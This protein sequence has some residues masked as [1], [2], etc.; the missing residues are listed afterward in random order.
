MKARTFYIAAL[1]VVLVSSLLFAAPDGVGRVW[2]FPMVESEE[3]LTRWLTDN[4]FDPFRVVLGYG[5]IRL[6][7]VKENEC[8]RITLKP[9]SPLAT[10]IRALYTQNGELDEDK[11]EVLWVHLK[12]Y[13]KDFHRTRGDTDQAIPKAILSQKE[14]VVCIKAFVDREHIQFSGFII[15]GEGLIISTAH[16]LQGIQE[17]TVSLYN[18]RQRNGHIV[19]IDFDRDVALLKIDMISDSF[20]SLAGGRHLV[21]TGEKIYS[22]GCPINHSG[23]IHSGV[24]TGPPRRANGL[25]LLQVRMEVFPGSSGSPVFDAQGHV[26]GMVKGRYRGTNSVGFLIPLDT[27]TAFLREI[28]PT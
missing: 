21:S 7:A 16:D 13:S 10:E 11:I 17:I 8:W 1:S 26:I 15:D 28:P 6:Q 25:T 19:A 27:I 20:I 14:H 3:V 18:G 22:I 24:I 12:D 2:P 23:I 5:S 4:G 9:R